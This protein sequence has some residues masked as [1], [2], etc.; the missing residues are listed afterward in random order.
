MNSRLTPFLFAVLS[1]FIVMVLYFNQNSFLES[2][3][4]KTYDLR[5]SNFR[6]SIPPVSD[7][8]IV[9]IDDKSIEELGRFPWSRIQYVRL[10]NKL[11]AAGAK[12]LIIDALFS[13]RETLE[14]DSAF[15]NAIRMAG[16]VDL[17][18]F[19]DFDKDMQVKRSTHTIPELER[20]AAGI[21]HINLFA[22]D[23]LPAL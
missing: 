1:V 17:A 21:G 3:E 16:N 4:A 8:A 23:R 14:I 6:G 12:V 20:F 19:F 11:S 10:V 13:E 9:A 2:L 5:L 15:S 7:I 18:V 22:E